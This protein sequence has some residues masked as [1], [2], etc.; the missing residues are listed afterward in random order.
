MDPGFL[1]RL[2]RFKGSQ[3]CYVR[4]SCVQVIATKIF[5]ARRIRGNTGISTPPSAPSERTCELDNPVALRHPILKYAIV[6][7]TLLQYIPVFAATLR[8]ATTENSVVT[9]P[10]R[11]GN[12]WSFFG[13]L[14]LKIHP[15]MPAYVLSPKS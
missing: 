9:K 1:Q 7:Y 8:G 14:G 6:Y 12:A 10:R 5:K 13:L 4:N 3:E 15:T 11:S 2:E